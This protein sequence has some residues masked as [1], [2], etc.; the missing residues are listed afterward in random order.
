MCIC[1]IFVCSRQVYKYARTCS[2]ASWLQRFVDR[3]NCLEI[4]LALNQTN[5][6]VNGSAARPTNGIDYFCDNIGDRSLHVQIISLSTFL[7]IATLIEARGVA[8]EFTS[9]YSKQKYNLIN[10][11]Q[12]TQPFSHTPDVIC[13][14]SQ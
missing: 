11:S 12:S 3:C 7:S 9:I 5:W 10:P 2:F 1:N 6:T 14:I 13:V 8:L 4:H